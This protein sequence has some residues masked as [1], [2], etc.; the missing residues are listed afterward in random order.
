MKHVGFIGLGQMGK[1]MAG[2]IARHP[3]NLCVYDIDA[4]AVDRLVEQGAKPAG[5]P[6]EVAA[7]ADV[8]LLSLPNAGVADDILHGEKGVVQAARPGMILVDCG[9]SGYLWT[10]KTAAVLAGQG[11]LMLDAPVTGLEQK[12]REAALT[13][14]VGGTEDVF[15][16]VKPVLHTVG[17]TIIYMGKIGCGQ[18]AKMI[19]NVIYNANMATL[20]EILPMAVKLG[21]APENI[22]DVVN[23]GSGRSFASEFFIEKILADRF[24]D[25]YSLG[26]AYKDMRHMDEAVAELNISLPIFRAAMDTYQ[27][28]LGAG[29]GGEDKGSMIKVFEKEMGV[30]FRKGV[31]RKPDDL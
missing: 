17:E 25:T 22:A 11:I 14:M 12:A 28:A 23:T 1:W 20:A 7:Q 24:T 8:I 30:L 29:L 5:S 19:N 18:L 31:F 4:S 15:E 10:R 26:N 9:T 21:L 3:F 16:Q 2:N 13:I 6:S 27:K